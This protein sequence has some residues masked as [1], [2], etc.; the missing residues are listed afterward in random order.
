MAQKHI[1]TSTP[2]DNL[3]D[4][5]RDANIKCEDNFTELYA[6]KVD[7]ISGKGLSTNDYTTAEK[8]KLAGIPADAE[9][10]VQSDWLVNDP[11]SDAFIKNKPDL[12]SSVNWGEINGTLSDQSDLQ[13][14]LDYKPTFEYVDAK[15]TQTI[16]VGTTEYAPSEDA[17]FNGLAVKQNVSEKNIANGYAGLDAGGKILTS[18]LP[19]SV[20]EYKGVY[21]AAT[22]TPALVNGTGN[23]GDVYRVTVSGAGVNSLNFVIGDYVVYNGSTWE[24][25]HSGS[26]NVVSVFG[27]AGVISAQIGDYTTAQVTETTNKNYQSDNQKLYN[28][29]TSS[30]QTQLDSK[31]TIGTAFTAGRIPYTTSPNTIVDS[32]RLL[33]ANTSSILEINGSNPIYRIKNNLNNYFGEFNMNAGGTLFYKNHQGK[34]I[35]T[36]TNPV[37]IIEQPQFAI[38]Q[39]SV[40]PVESQLYVY[41]GTN[42]ANIDAR[43]LDTVD[44]ANIDLQGNDW[45]S[46]GVPNSLGFS[47][48]G[49]NGRPG[50]VLGYAKN[51]L[52]QIRFQNSS[53]A[54]ITS[55]N[56]DSSITPIRFGINTT[57]VASISNNGLLLNTE[58]ENTIAGFD[59]SKRLK[60]LNTVTY[61]TLLELS[62]VKGAASSIQ[63]Q[64]NAKEPN[65]IIGST[66]QYY[67]GDKSWQTL[68]KTAV[69]LANV[70]NTADSTKNVLSATK[71]TT[72]RT[73][74]GVGF[75]GTANITINATDS[76]LRLALSGGTLTGGLTGTTGT[77]TGVLSATTIYG[78][79]NGVKKYVALVAQSGT[80]APTVTVLENS[81]GNIVW[82]RTATGYYTGTLSSAF[83]T[84]KCTF[85][86]T[87]NTPSPTSYTINGNFV[88]TNAV[89]YNT[90]V[91]GTGTDNL[92]LATIDISVYP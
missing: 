46:S 82:S 13:L 86:A 50:T 77:F 22:N 1:N 25:Q 83:P 51:K 70:D 47:Y 41:G 60:S 11:D 16:N 20:M 84:G 33:W 61:P 15:V 49:S 35:F 8:T 78:R 57:E 85:L 43:G 14:A 81:V 75:D 38:G 30:I 53:T 24:K 23:T 10:N 74:N 67:R 39:V 64:L 21:N 71:L 2:N 6:N 9:K 52:A 76:I 80:T 28:D 12:I 72:A 68:N 92:A 89:A 65:I 48:F 54:L 37:S 5:L 17:V 73:I 19:N 27:R 34:N 66:S 63:T 56:E 29:A 32:S 40:V 18:Q 88:S 58:I 7:K 36:V 91:G 44:E 26:D 4:T 79:I 90:L 31:T 62:Y 69:G 3:G 55:I 87:T 59:A 45:E 42:G